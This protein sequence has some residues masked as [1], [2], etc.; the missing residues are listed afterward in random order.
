MDMIDTHIHLWDLKHLTY[1]FLLET[2]PAEEAVIGNYDAIKKNY[3]IGDYL[4][5][6]RGC[7][8]VK[9]VHI[10]AALNHP[11]PV[12][13]TEWLQGI[14]DRHGYP[15]AIIGFC[16]L[17]GGDAEEVLDG[18]LAYTNFRGIRMLGTIGM[19]ETEPFQRG[20]AVLA[21]RNLIYE[22]DA[23]LQD[24]PAAHRLANKFSDTP[25][26]LTHTG[27]PMERSDQYFLAW[28]QGMRS[29]VQAQNVVCK[30]SGLGMTDHHWTTA[31]I[32]P[33]VEAA[34]NAFGPQRCMFGTNWPVDSL[35]SPY[36]AVVE[37]YREILRSFS[38]DEQ[39]RMLTGTAAELY[40][41]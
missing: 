5:D 32:R 20:F 24:M 17:S 37:A 28:R 18:H 29:F 41:I 9:A 36:R 27:M 7:G 38:N 26:V 12:E 11:R 10:Q 13:E 40:G 15:Q 4:A 1:S 25:I 22:L 21:R 19:L 35:Y 2:D 14:A 30:I 33:W 3:L 31:S 6:I 16:D 34:I 39:R 8:I 23:T